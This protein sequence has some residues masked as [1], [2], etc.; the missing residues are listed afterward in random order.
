MPKFLRLLLDFL[1][2]PDAKDGG[3]LEAG[4]VGKEV[5]SEASPTQIRKRFKSTGK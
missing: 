4:R 5:T 1:T 3:G 2:L